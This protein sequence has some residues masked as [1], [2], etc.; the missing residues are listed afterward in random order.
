[1]NIK[2]FRLT[3]G[4]YLLSKDMRGRGERG[5]EREEGE[6]FSLKK[7]QLL[8]ECHSHTQ[9]KFPFSI[10]ASICYFFFLSFPPPCRL[11]AACKNHHQHSPYRFTDVPFSRLLWEKKKQKKQN[12]WQ[13]S[14]K[15]EFINPRGFIGFCSKNMFG[16]GSNIKEL[17]KSQ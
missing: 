13:T 12:E 1:M 3:A 8:S 14:E 9:Q 7:K 4:A 15:A 17:P 6:R 2:P 5:R 16:L 11:Q 10:M